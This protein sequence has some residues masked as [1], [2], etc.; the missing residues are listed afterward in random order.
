MV[1]LVGA[2]RP[3]AKLPQELGKTYGSSLHVSQNGE[4]DY[5]LAWKPINGYP[6][7]AG[8]A[9][10]IS[11]AH[12]RV[13]RGLAIDVPVLVGASAR[14]FKG[15]YAEPAHHADSVLNVDDMARYGPRLGRDATVMRIEGG[16]H[17]LR[18]LLYVDLDEVQMVESRPLDGT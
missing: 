16:K 6:V 17:D 7:Y 13:Q 11:L 10:A 14:S 5:D 12:R 1:N 4:W 8:W 9:R 2:R 18:L 15:R 3:M